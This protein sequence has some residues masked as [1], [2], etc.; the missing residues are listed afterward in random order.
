LAAAG[1]WS[2]N[3]VSEATLAAE[4]H[5]EEGE[6]FISGTPNVRCGGNI[7]NLILLS[8]SFGNVRLHELV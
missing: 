1:E 5:G 8:R 3:V 4:Q 2:R 6:K 7:R